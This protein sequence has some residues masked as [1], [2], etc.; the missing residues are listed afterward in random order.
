MWEK[1]RKLNKSNSF[2]QRIKIDLIININYNIK[3]EFKIKIFTEKDYFRALKLF[4][5]IRE[6]ELKE[7][8]T[9]YGIALTEEEFIKNEHDKLFKKILEIPKEVESVIRKAVDLGQYDKLELESVRNEFVT[10]DYKGKQVDI[11]YK[12]KGKEV[13]F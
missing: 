13:Y 4:P 9:T 10:E 5:Q 11:L 2:Y 6:I 12:L 7:K 8:D 1:K 3:E